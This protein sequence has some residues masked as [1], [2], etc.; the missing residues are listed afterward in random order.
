MIAPVSANTN[1]TL[2]QIQAQMEIDNN[3]IKSDYDKANPKIHYRWAYLAGGLGFAG[4]VVYAFHNKTGFWKGLGIAL[5]FNI[6]GAGVGAGVD[7]FRKE[8]ASF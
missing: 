8:N 7:S 2:E 4:G 1:L 6:V 5:I 3:K